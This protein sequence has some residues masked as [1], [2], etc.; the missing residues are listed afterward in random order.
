MSTLVDNGQLDKA[1]AEELISTIPLIPEVER[2][3][4]ELYTDHDG[5]PAF[6]LIFHVRR[7]V[8]VDK[9]F[10]RRY[11]DFSGVFETKILHSDLNRFPYTRLEQAA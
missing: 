10:I 7:E 3:E 11:I 5:D 1:K 2:I 8:E 6:Q 9:A 4:V